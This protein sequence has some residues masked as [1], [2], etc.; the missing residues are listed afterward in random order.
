MAEAKNGE[1]Y[2]GT[3]KG[4][5]RFTNIKLE[6]VVMTSRDGTQ[7]FKLKEVFL[8]GN[9]L[10]YFRIEEEVLGNLEGTQYV[11]PK[12]MKA[13]EGRKGRKAFHSL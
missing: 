10:K 8:K 2:N 7:F 11:T 4:V 3:L 1:T 9:S 6:N 12:W 13:G 5:D